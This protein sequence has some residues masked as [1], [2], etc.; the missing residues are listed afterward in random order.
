MEEIDT[1]ICRKKFRKS[2][3]NIKKTLVTWKNDFIII[4]IILCIV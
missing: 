2:W 1:E 4:I 3:K